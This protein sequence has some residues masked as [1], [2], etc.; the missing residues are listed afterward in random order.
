[1]EFCFARAIGVCCYLLLAADAESKRLLG[2]VCSAQMYVWDIETG[3]CCGVIGEEGD[4][5]VTSLAVCP[6]QRIVVAASEQTV[7]VYQADRA[8]L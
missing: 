7:H 1:M 6:K 8:T 2:V 3:S 5:V 4:S